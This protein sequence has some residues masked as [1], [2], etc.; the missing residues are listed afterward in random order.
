MAGTIAYS[1][2]SIHALLDGWLVRWSFYRLQGGAWSQGLASIH[3]SCVLAVCK[4]S[5]HQLLVI[6]NMTVAM[7]RGELLTLIH[8]GR[9]AVWDWEGALSSTCDAVV[10]GDLP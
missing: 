6:S 9:G 5:G 4:G 10:T 1:L 2:R 7:G 8:Q 3:S